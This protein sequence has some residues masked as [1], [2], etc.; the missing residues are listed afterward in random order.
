MIL[1]VMLVVIPALSPVPRGASAST[2]GGG[3]NIQDNSDAK[4]GSSTPEATVK[5]PKQP[6]PPDPNT[7]KIGSE[8]AEQSIKLTSL[9]P[10]TITEKQKTFWDHLYDWGPWVFTGLLVVVG[11]LQVAT[12]A[13]QAW[14]LKGT[15]AEIH[16]QANWM[17]TQAARMSRQ[18]DLMSRQ[19]RIAIDSARAT[20][21]AA[22]AAKESANAAK[23]GAEAAVAQ[24]NLIKSKERARVWIEIKGDLN[25]GFQPL[26]VPVEYT[27]KQTGPTDAFVIESKAAVVISSDVP[28]HSRYFSPINIPS[29]LAPNYEEEIKTPFLRHFAKEDVPRVEN[30]TAI[31]YFIARIAYRDIFGEMHETAVLREWHITERK[32]LIGYGNFAY[33]A[34]CG[35]TEANRET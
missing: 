16:K 19:N 27:V 25:L 3:K 21:E 5:Q 35:P 17:E 24:I 23:T 10:V 4:K 28:E 31:A 6:D 7:Q 22:E 26:S 8:N 12:M 1:A 29:R 2:R 15:L 18:I 14:L 13:W 33:W 11:F 20:R 34:P 32:K 9:P 30:Q